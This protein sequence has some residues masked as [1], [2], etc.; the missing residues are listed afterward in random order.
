MEEDFDGVKDR[1]QGN[2]HKTT[3]VQRA[4]VQPCLFQS[5]V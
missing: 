1:G 4:H 3:E 2:P 5:G